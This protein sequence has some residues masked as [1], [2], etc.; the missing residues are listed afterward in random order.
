ML[1][2]LA[3]PRQRLVDAEWDRPLWRAAVRTLCHPL[4]W[5]W[6]LRDPAY[7]ARAQVPVA[8]TLEA[9]LLGA[10]RRFVV[11]ESFMLHLVL[12]G[13]Q[14]KSDVPPYLTRAGYEV[15]RERIDS[16][17]IVDG[18]LVGYLSEG[19]HGRFSGFSL[20]DVPSFLDRRG[21]DHLL[22][23]VLASAEA[24]AR[25]VVRQFLTRYDPASRIG[26]RLERD[27]SLEAR[28]AREDRAFGYEFLIADLRHASA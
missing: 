21:F 18:D 12:A 2:H 28:C 13:E 10:L 1:G 22:A 25:L 3:E 5:R 17:E 15:L 19:A 11:S 8:A 14:S 23:G 26:D 16:L 4:V 9:R 24:D 20:S 6:L 27:R 7:Y